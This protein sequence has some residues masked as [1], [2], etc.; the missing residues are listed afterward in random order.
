ML[1]TLPTPTIVSTL[2]DLQTVVRR[3]QKE[4]LVAVDTE[5]NSLFAYREQ[6]CL[7]QLSTRTNDWVVD[8]LALQDLTALAP[9]F[10]DPNIEKVF[11]ASE[12]DIL[13]MKRDFGF[14]FANLFDTM[15]TARIIG[16]KSFVLGAMLEEHSGVAVNKR[17]MRAGWS[18]RPIR[19]KQLRY[20]QQDTHYLPALRDILLAQLTEGGHI[21]EAHEAFEW[22][23]NLP[24][25]DHA[26][27]PEGYWRINEARDFNRRQMAI[28]RELY[29]FRDQLARK[30]D[31]PPFKVMGDSGL[32]KIADAAP[33]TLD[34]LKQLSSGLNHHLVERHGNA[35]LQAVQ[36]GLHAHPPAPPQRT[37]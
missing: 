8:P 25:A 16:L 29:L 5:S 12:Y 36:R 4:S 6:V 21:E 15:V 32:V 7:V 2:D 1:S 28:L 13:C 20:A 17:Y 30:R 14:T 18:I 23:A 11:H 24:A 10:A 3:L 35:I 27:D 9:L 34:D 33:A 22:L 37:P 19:P 31:L 26:F